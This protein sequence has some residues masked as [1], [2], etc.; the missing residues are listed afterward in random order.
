METFCE[1]GDEKVRKETLNLITYVETEPACNCD[2]QA[3]IPAIKSVKERDLLP[4]ELVVDTLYGSDDN[5]TEAEKEGVR[6]IAPTP[7]TSEKT[8]VSLADFEFSGDGKVCRCP[9]NQEPEFVSQNK[10]GN[11]SAG[12]DSSVCGRCPF[13]KECPA[14][15]GKKYHYLRY[16]D[17]SVRISKRRAE[18]KNEEFKDKY[19]WRAGVEAT[20][21]EY[22]SRTGVKH[23][24]VRGGKN[25]RYCARLKAIGVNIFRAAAVR[26]ARKR[27][28]SPFNNPLFSYFRLFFNVK[29]RI[30]TDYDDLGFLS[31]NY[32]D[33]YNSCLKLDFGIFLTGEWHKIN[34]VSGR[35]HL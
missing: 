30:R 17:K 13:E 10:K 27:R 15:K 4:E 9:N 25:V 32:A 2:A 23:L 22:D 1:E 31:H 16:N 29:E 14:K 6:L 7:G 28:E 8:S 35:L 12:F 21:S 34:Q 24:R 3:L 20:M 33:D 5:I 18:E 11:Y 19:R 26:K